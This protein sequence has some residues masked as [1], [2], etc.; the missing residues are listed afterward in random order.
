M[1]SISVAL[2]RVSFHSENVFIGQAD[3]SDTFRKTTP[4]GEHIYVRETMSWGMRGQARARERKTQ[5][6]KKRECERMKMAKM[7]HG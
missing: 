7:L 2:G 3:D 5:R 4:S 6:G 1:V